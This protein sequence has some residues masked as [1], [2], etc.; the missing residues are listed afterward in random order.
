MCTFWVLAK[1][2]PLHNGDFQKKQCVLSPEK[3]GIWHF[4]A[5]FF[6]QVSKKRTDLDRSFLY[7]LMLGTYSKFARKNI[8]FQRSA[9]A[10]RSWPQVCRVKIMF[11]ELLTNCF[12]SNTKKSM[13]CVVNWIPLRIRVRSRNTQ[14][15]L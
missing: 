4:A 2:E 1:R 12:V 7:I 13:K 8:I 14:P 6:L 15:H 9:F 3:I 10:F 11:S 5:V